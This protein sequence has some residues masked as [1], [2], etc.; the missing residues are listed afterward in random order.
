MKINIKIDGKDY[1]GKVNEVVAK[2]DPEQNSITDFCVGDV[3]E[4]ALVS[5]VVIVKTN[6]TR[7]PLGENKEQFVFGGLHDKPFNIY[8]N[9]PM[10]RAGVLKWLNKCNCICTKNINTSLSLT[11]Q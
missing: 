2:A 7:N 8:A 6:Y 9:D 1:T 11:N 3:F 4:S 10:D 5:P